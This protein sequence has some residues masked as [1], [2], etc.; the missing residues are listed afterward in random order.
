MRRA[1]R[2]SHA[3]RPRRPPWDGALAHP[4]FNASL[5][6]L[7]GELILKRYYHL[8]VVVATDCGLIVPVVRD[9]HGQP[10]LEIARE[11][12]PVAARA[13]EGRSGSRGSGGT[14]TIT[15]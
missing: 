15:N 11:L 12:A 9:A 7:T 8:G 4:Q 10:V 14:F 5:D 13:R 1:A 2:R 6:A 3:A